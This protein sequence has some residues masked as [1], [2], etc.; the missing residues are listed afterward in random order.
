MKNRDRLFG[1]KEISKILGRKN[2]YCYKVMRELNQE[3]KD[4]GFYI[5]DG[6]IP[7]KYFCDRLCLDVDG[8]LDFLNGGTE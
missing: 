3:L 6:K 8:V 5:V 1:V 4:Q 2:S 7:A